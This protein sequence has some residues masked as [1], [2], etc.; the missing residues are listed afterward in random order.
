MLPVLPAITRRRILRGVQRLVLLSATLL[1]LLRFAT[2]GQEPIRRC[3]EVRSLSRE[4]AAEMRPVEV[5][6]V[7]T[8]L[9]RGAVVLQDDTEGIY[10]A[11]SG[12]RQDWGG[13]AAAHVG[14]QLEVR[15]VTGPGGFAPVI[16]ASEVK[17][18]G[19]GELPP[20]RQHTLTELRTGAFDCQRVEMRG[21]AQRIHQS[22]T[23]EGQLR[24]EI[25]TLDGSFSAFLADSR[26]LD[27][28]ALVDAELRLTGVCLTFF[29]TRGEAVGVHLQILAASGIEILTPAVGDPFA[30]P[31]VA[32]LALR[33]FSRKPPSLHRQRL[34]GIVTLAR[35]G[36]FFYVQTPLRSVR[37]NT[38]S[39][40]VLT[41]G[42]E[43][44]ASGFVAP[45]QSF[46]V[47]DEAIVR[48]TGRGAL[49][50]PVTI[51]RQQV[52]AVKAPGTNTLRQEDYDGTLVKLRGRLVKIESN[53]GEEHRLYLD[54][55]GS[56]V[57]ATLGAQIPAAAL[58]HFAAG[59][60]IEATGICAVRL[61]ARWP[62]L[63]I[64]VPE[65]FTLLLHAPESV[66]LLSTP[67]WWTPQRLWTALGLTGGVLLLSLAWV[68]TLRRRVARRSAALADEMRARRD[69]AVEFDTTLR[70]R[71]RLAADLHDTLEQ[72]LTGL[73]LQ[74]EAAAA[75]QTEAPARSSQHLGLARQLLD[76][77][78]EDVRRS[79]WELRTNPLE[80][81]TLTEALRCIAADRSAGLA[82]R[83][84]VESEGEAQPMPDF[85]AG[86]LLLLAQE[87][88]TNALK[89]AAPQQITLRLISTKSEVSLSIRDDGRGFTPGSAPGPREGHFGL[90]GMRERAK[91]L[92]GTLTIESAVGAGACIAVFVPASQHPV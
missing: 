35:P 57:I 18:L 53:A 91:R 16:V 22:D 34:A 40:E 66:R 12:A 14:M 76:R 3:A 21:V 33:P 47:L 1:V 39:T 31:E 51:T 42:D 72:S 54:C 64:P 44:E 36:E 70:E 65:D 27:P 90:Q 38:R 60:D 20:A 11:V 9:L 37:V 17:A 85:V 49:P 24:L 46:A 41:P 63:V 59:S 78:R 89:H 7:V 56:V 8:F 30:V 74:L 82:V 80:G 55:A 45:T 79:V 69:A 67:S 68:W 50:E 81:N 88:I 87:G 28:D 6:G 73:A 84:T 29:N 61:S 86:N 10:V 77:S 71:T 52:L 43:I 83:I 75:L 62:A 23:E 5:R 92:G 26:G 25:A 58:A 19:E 2:S 15:G 32:P 48:R 4:Q 13:A